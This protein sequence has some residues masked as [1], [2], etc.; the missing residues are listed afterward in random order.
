MIDRYNTVWLNEFSWC[1]R[2]TNTRRCKVVVS[3][4][5]LRVARPGVTVCPVGPYPLSV[6]DRFDGTIP[7]LTIEPLRGRA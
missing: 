4:R 1:V 2:G 5:P 7:A 6:L 3:N